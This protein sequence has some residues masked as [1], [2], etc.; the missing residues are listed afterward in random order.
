MGFPTALATWWLT[1]NTVMALI[2]RLGDERGVT[3]RS[4]TEI[5]DLFLDWQRGVD[6]RPWF[7]FI[8]LFDTHEPY[9]AP[10]PFDRTFTD[11]RLQTSIDLARPVLLPQELEEL[12]LSYDACIR[13]LDAELRRVLDALAAAG[14]LDNTLVILTS[15]HG[16]QFGEHRNDITRHGL[17]LYMPVLHVPLVLRFPPLGAAVRRPELVSLRDLPA[18][19]MDI[20]D[21][22]PSH[23]FPGR[24]LVD[25][26]LRPEPILASVQKHLQADIW[27]DWPSSAGDMHS[28]IAEPWHYIR[29]ARGNQFLF[30]IVADFN[31]FNDLARVPALADTLARMRLLLDSLLAAPP[32][33]PAA[34]RSRPD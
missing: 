1:R 16:E 29:D 2:A 14:S 4:A 30:D 27:A 20:V 13:Y 31:E 12:E 11:R 6:D 32:P 28:V 15:D 23:P 3:R 8:N 9:V 34:A 7:A 33:L 18:T 24:S 17:S 10:A 5:N 22:D 26:T 19:I 21:G 25:D